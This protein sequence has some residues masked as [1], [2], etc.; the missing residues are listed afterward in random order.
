MIDNNESGINVDFQ[1]QE[2]N[3]LPPCCLLSGFPLSKVYSWWKKIFWKCE[4]K[5]ENEQLL[6]SKLDPKLFRWTIFQL[7]VLLWKLR[8]H[9]DPQT[10]ES[11][12][13]VQTF[14]ALFWTVVAVCWR[15]QFFPTCLHP[16]ITRVSF[17]F[18]YISRYSIFS[19]FINLQST[20]K[21]VQFDS[22]LT[23]KY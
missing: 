10:D 18:K 16:E 22:K 2:Y 8:R 20:S 23:L 5:Y 1:P 19:P 13:K 21:A 11:L 9:Q 14:H 6:S 4:H 17:E 15:W 3:F 12:V 7:L